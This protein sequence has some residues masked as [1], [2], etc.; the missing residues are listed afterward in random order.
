[1][2]RGIV[3][4][5]RGTSS[6]NYTDLSTSA[7]LPESV[8]I[9]DHNPLCIF[10]LFLGDRRAIFLFSTTFPN[11]GIMSGSMSR[12]RLRSR[13]HVIVRVDVLAMLPSSVASVQFIDG[14]VSLFTRF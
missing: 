4:N 3:I 8:T 1:M 11:S 13:S 9:V 2:V 6:T 10:I 12:C 7:A 14:M 5:V